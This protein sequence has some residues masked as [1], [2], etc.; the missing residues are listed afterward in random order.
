MP[1]KTYQ[2]SCTKKAINHY[3]AFIPSTNI[4]TS[5]SMQRMQR[6]EMFEVT[7]M[8]C[9]YKTLMHACHELIDT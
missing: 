5:Y 6:C 4:H 2:L 8:Q 7:T 3:N 9:Q 1:L